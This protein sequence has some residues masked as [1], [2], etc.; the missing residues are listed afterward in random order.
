MY[1]NYLVKKEEKDYY[2]LK[3]FMG[4]FFLVL[5]LAYTSLY[6]IQNYYSD[7]IFS[8]SQSSKKIYVLKSDTLNMMYDKK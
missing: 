7:S 3:L 6:A 2:G 5:I 4:L 8:F 1:V